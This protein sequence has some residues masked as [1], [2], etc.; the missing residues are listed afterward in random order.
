[1]T[2]GSGWYDYGTSIWTGWLTDEGY[3]ALAQE[4]ARDETE[5]TT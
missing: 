2:E 5:E 4:V 1:M 3:H